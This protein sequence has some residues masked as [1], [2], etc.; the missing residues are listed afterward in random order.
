V[1]NYNLIRRLKEVIGSLALFFFPFIEP[2]AVTSN[3]KTEE[4]EISNVM[5]L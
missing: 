3:P 5:I 1:C 4:K 2:V